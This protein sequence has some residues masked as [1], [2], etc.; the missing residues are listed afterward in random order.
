MMGNEKV[1]GQILDYIPHINYDKVAD[2]TRTVS[3]F[4]TTIRHLGGLLSG[5][6]LGLLNPMAHVTDKMQ[7][8]T[9]SRKPWPASRSP[10]ARLC[11]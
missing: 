11:R 10:T 6:A 5:I 4:E 9:C 1:I 3:L 2:P 8:T 7:P